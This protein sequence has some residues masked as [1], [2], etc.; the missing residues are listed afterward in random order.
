MG[1]GENSAACDG[2][3]GRS[4]A[5][6]DEAY[7]VLERYYGDL[8]CSDD[9]ELYRSVGGGV[10]VGEALATLNPFR[11]PAVGSPLPLPQ[12]CG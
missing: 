1:V 5:S 10:E 11:F 12:Q 7:A 3:A 4:F 2:I 8:C 9:R 6:C